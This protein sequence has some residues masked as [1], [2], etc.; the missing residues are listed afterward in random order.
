[1]NKRAAKKQLGL[2]CTPRAVYAE[3]SP[4]SYTYLAYWKG[5]PYDFQSEKQHSL[6]VYSENSHEFLILIS[7][8]PQGHATSP[9]L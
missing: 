4:S 3:Q 9:N 7:A 5:H 8:L 2:N 6:V 1:M